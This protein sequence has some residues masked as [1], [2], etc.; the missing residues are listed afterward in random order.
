LTISQTGPVSLYAIRENFDKS[1]RTAA[2]D[3]YV[4]DFRQLEEGESWDLESYRGQAFGL[5]YQIFN[6]GYGGGLSGGNLP[7]DEIDRRAE[8]L[9]EGVG[10]VSK[11]WGSYA[12]L[13]EDDKGKYAE[14]QAMHY[15]MESPGAI[16]MNG[17][18][19]ADEA[20]PDVQY[21]LRATVE[22]ADNWPMND[23]NANV[24]VFGYRYGYL[25]GDRRN[26]LLWGYNEKPD[27]G[28]TLTVDETFTVDENYRHIV[29]NLQSWLKGRYGE[30]NRANLK[31]RDLTI[32][33]V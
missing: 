20:G 19:F 31:V 21:R 7:L 4:R 23:G 16:S 17:I 18:W 28:Q 15:Q 30:L 12:T 11:S 26:Y 33:R 9:L 6:D 14:I 2:D 29:V 3:R 13:G 32:E 10:F 22:T 8:G 25:D 1:G 5:Q 24:F 27:A